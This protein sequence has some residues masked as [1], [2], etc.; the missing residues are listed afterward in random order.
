MPFRRSGRQPGVAVLWA[1]LPILLGIG[2]TLWVLLGAREQQRRSDRL[3]LERHSQRIARIL[4]S[5]MT[6]YEDLLRGV[7]AFCRQVNEPTPSAWRAYSNDLDFLHRHPGLKTLVKI[8]RVQQGDLEGFLARN[9]RDGFPPRICEV[10]S[11]DPSDTSLPL[12]GPEHLVINRAE[13]S[14]TAS[15][16]L[17]MDVGTS[18]HQRRAAERAAETGRPALTGPLQFRV[19]GTTQTA[20][21]LFFPIYRGQGALPPVEE[22][23]RE[24]ASWVSLGIYLDA[25]LEA[26]KEGS[27]DAVS[28]EIFDLSDGAAIRLHP[29]SGSP[30]EEA[31]GDQ[32]VRR[33]EVFGRTWG[34]VSRPLPT[35]FDGPQRNREPQ[36]LVTGLVASLSLGAVLW[37]LASTRERAH[38]MAMQQTRSM[39]EALRRLD[40]LIESTPVG[41]VEWDSRLRVRRWNPAAE[42]IFGFEAEE[43]LENSGSTFR[44]PGLAGVMAR[45]A[46][47]GVIQ[48]ARSVSQSHESVRKD[49]QRVVC[50]WTSSPIYD[51]EGRVEG[52]L[53][54]VMDVTERRMTEERA[55]LHQKL[56]SLGVMAGGIAHDFNNLLWAISGNAELARDRVPPE[57]PAQENLTRIES[58]AFRAADLA[59]QMLAF[60]GRAPFVIRP[61]DLGTI[62]KGVEEILRAAI[63]R[64]IRLDFLVEEGIPEVKGDEGHIQQALSNLLT[65][66]AEAVGEAGGCVRV[67][68]YQAIVDETV[69]RDLVPGSALSEGTSVCIE[70]QD[71]GPGMDPETLAK[72]F[73][74]FFT[75]RST[76]RGLGLS[77]TLG[78]MKA[79]GGGIA[80]E[81]SVG[82]GT[83]VRLYFPTLCE[84]PQEHLKEPFA[85]QGARGGTILLAEDE[86]I[87]RELTVEALEPAGFRVITAEDGLR[88]LEIFEAHASEISI[89]VMDLNMPRMGGLEAFRRLRALDPAVKVILCSGFAEEEIG[90]WKDD[91]RPDGFLHKPYRLRDLI[92]MVGS[93]I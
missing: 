10:K 32:E 44:V 90:E 39:R 53:S 63:P 27:D 88:A 65:N 93:L 6:G 46:L 56:E 55:W 80:L 34:L 75:T 30:F 84:S 17:G 86:E 21:A 43:V 37:S 24:V 59:R 20:V 41:V 12:E 64:T 62:L 66:A 91:L 49:G 73:D 58:A 82:R 61:L 71:E 13:P 8:E 1:L 4:E 81:S 45:S 2:V 89:V 52:V 78:I 5:R 25:F 3:R 74:P 68:V 18:L 33:L 79:H 9:R 23:R 36:I 16:A 42:K 69:L 85:P 51:P 92:R 22:R 77:A 67:K 76:G 26:V 70:I 14:E 40:M 47:E 7:H 48:E 54:L 60:A 31:K 83:S 19:G 50:E 28:T 38:H 57:S 72:V 35:F 29:K 15:R 11:L 87:L